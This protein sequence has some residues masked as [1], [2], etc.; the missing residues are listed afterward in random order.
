MKTVVLVPYCPLP[1]HS[2]GRAEMWK[3][4]ELLR[5]MG[6]CTIAS[7]ATRPVGAGWTPELRRD[8]EQRGY[9]VELREASVR[10]TPA[11][12][13]GIAYAAVCKALRL[14]RAFGHAN[15]YH[16]HAFPAEWWRRVTEGADLAVINYSYWARLPCACP[17]AVLLLDLWSDFMWGGARRETADLKT[18]DLVIV[19]SKDEERTL[20]ARGVAR[21]FW[22]PPVVEPMDLPDAPAVG[23]LGSPSPVNREGL[24]WFAAAANATRLPVR[25]YGGLA[26]HAQGPGFE[27]VGRYAAEADPYRECGVILMTTV[28][29]MGVQI[30]TIEAL[31]AGRAIVARRGAMRGIPPGEGAWLEVDTPQAMMQAAGRL[32]GNAAERIAL[33][34]RARAYHAAHLDGARIRAGLAAAL[35]G[36]AAPAGRP[37]VSGGVP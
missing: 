19:I 36:L 31:A 30:K 13:A 10:R 28:L 27:R 5:G 21:T 16:R 15:P 9:R 25:V 20:H 12:A 37:A 14:E 18:A 3:L 17:K 23:L 6:D 34:G 35:S 7:A 24:R 26:A 2:G 1:A 4:L 22:S 33:G 11:M 29:G 32:A 8:L